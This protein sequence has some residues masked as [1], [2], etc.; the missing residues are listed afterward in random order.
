MSPWTSAVGA[1]QLA[2]LLGSQHTRD[3]VAAG[4]AASLTG[5]RRVPAYRSLADGV[6]LL[7][8]EGRVPVAARL[9]AER[10][11]A[12][13][14][15][16]SRTTVAAAYEALRGEGFLESRRGAGSWTAMPAGSPLPT[17]GSTRSRPRPRPP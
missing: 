17:R 14:L 7:I 13:A 6:R 16:V 9:P 1:P 4:A 12:A 8:L 5:G 10:E 15:A 2:R 3:G 11:L